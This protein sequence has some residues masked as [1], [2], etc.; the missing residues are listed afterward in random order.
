MRIAIV[1]YAGH[2]FQVQLS[3][4]LARR[5]HDVLHLWF[6]EIQSPKGKLEVTAGDPQSL[7]IEPVSIGGN[8]AKQTLLKRRSQESNVGRLFAARIEAFAPEIVVA[9]NVPLDALDQI[10]SYCGRTGAAFVLWV[11]DL[12]SLAMER[13]LTRRIGP[14]G[15][16]VGRYYRR[17]ERRAVCSSNAVVAIS[18][19][20]VPYLTKIYNAKPNAV[21]VI[22]NWAPLDEIVVCPKEN[23]WSRAQGCVDKKVVLYSGTLGMKHNPS[24]ILGIAQQ[25]KAGGDAV[26]VVASEG[27]AADW[28][29]EQSKEQNLPLRVVGFQPFE[30]YSQVL[31]SADVLISIL[32]NDAGVFS[33]PSKVLS[34][35][36]AG[37]PIVLSAPAGNLA[38]K[39]VLSSG[40]G[41]V[42]AA[43]NGEAFTHSVMELLDDPTE[44]HRCGINGRRYAEMAFDL[45]QIGDKFE[46]VLST[47]SGEVRKVPATGNPSVL[48]AWAGIR[49][50]IGH[51]KKTAPLV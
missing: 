13:L 20:F 26:V 51:N 49:E 5:Q 28:L 30:V 41:R 22:E 4:E 10:R 9:A 6:K 33:V 34:Y 46:D 14:F 39:I 37:R 43:D 17:L 27:P 44:M 24:L 8:F 47:A 11:Q 31:A 42:V 23:I 1:D 3:R 7:T 21:R 36:C 29:A 12:I 40:A 32:E 38:A 2:P 15:V 18:D 45:R 16:L 50:K 19:D 35:M 48:G 25:L